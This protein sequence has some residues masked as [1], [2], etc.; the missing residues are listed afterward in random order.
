VAR[1]ATKKDVPLQLGD[2]RPPFAKGTASRN[3]NSTCTPGRDAQLVEQLDQLAVEISGERFFSSSEE[4]AV[5]GI[6]R[7][8]PLP[9]PLRRIR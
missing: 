2:A 1:K 3:A 8:R 6:T 9:S 7:S 5:A 4:V